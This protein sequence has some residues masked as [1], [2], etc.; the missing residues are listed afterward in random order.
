MTIPLTIETRGH[1]EQIYIAPLISPPLGLG[2][3][4]NSET[5]CN[6]VISQGP[7]VFLNYPSNRFI[8]HS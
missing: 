8:N 3:K 7:K 2:S 5:H 6:A 4:N 1:N